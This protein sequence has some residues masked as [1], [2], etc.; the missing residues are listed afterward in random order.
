MTAFAAR[1]ALAHTI[2]TK[3]IILY[4]LGDAR[5]PRAALPVNLLK[6]KS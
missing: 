2:S 4:N 1:S 3:Q 5:A 6:K